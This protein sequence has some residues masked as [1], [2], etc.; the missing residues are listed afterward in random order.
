MSTDAIVVLKDD[1][2]Q[3]RKLFRDFQA[4]GENATTTKGKIATRIIGS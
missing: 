3:I 2:Q 4:A 1:H